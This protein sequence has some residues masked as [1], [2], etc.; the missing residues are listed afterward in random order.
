MALE[1]ALLRILACPIDKIGAVDVYLVAHHGGADAA[2]PGTFAAFK[3][4]IAVMNN[5]EKKGGANLTYEMLHRIKGLEDVWQLHMS[6]A[7]G[8]NNFPVQT[9][10]N[11]DESTSHWLKLIANEDGSFALFNQRTGEWR[12]YRHR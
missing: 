9:V 8:S 12:R 11:L 5:G 3:P 1:S 4:R 10:A 2:D 7:A 6:A